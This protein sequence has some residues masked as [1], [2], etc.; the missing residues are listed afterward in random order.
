MNLSKEQLNVINTFCEEAEYG[1]R[2]SYSG[3][4]VW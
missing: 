3:R 4:N 2:E 1:F